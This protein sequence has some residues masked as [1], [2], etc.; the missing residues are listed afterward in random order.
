MKW[1]KDNRGSVLITLS[2]VVL[3]VL[4]G[5]F[6]YSLVDRAEAVLGEGGNVTDT[7]NKHNLSSTSNSTSVRASTLNRICIFCHTPHHAITDSSLLNAPLWNHTLST[8][9]Y[10]LND[11]PPYLSNRGGPGS[12]TYG[13]G[14]VNQ[15]TTPIQ[16]DGASKLCLSCHD[17]TVAIGDVASISNITMASHS[18][19]TSGRLNS[20]C[21]TYIGTNLTKKHVV[22]VPMNQALIDNSEA[23]C[24][25]GD[26]STYLR[27]PWSAGG[28]DDVKLRP[29]KA[30]YD[31]KY[32]V[33]GSAATSG[34]GTLYKA[35]YKYGVQC[36]TCHDP[37]YWD[38][39]DGNPGY[40]FLAV[41]RSSL[42][43]VCHITSGC[44]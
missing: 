29:T 10:I 34:G 21:S 13:P 41:T 14:I 27:Y 28:N 24:G 37:H 44:P 6:T 7:N 25:Q 2:A 1:I 19:L 38:G 39:S 26:S 30:T 15:L 33:D 4:F 12:P 31:S 32:G 22:S 36:S 23:V 17:G 35:G 3:G 18:C 16:P 9:T 5:L 8:A 42:C 40:K 11:T 43:G 20:S